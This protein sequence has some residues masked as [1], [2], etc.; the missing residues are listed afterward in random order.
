MFTFCDES[1]FY[2]LVVPYHHFLFKSTE[3]FLLA[4]LIICCGCFWGSG[5]TFKTEFYLGIG[6]HEEIAFFDHDCD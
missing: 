6:C 5:L 3:T 4:S 1:R 2:V